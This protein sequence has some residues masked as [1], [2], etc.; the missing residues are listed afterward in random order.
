VIGFTNG[1][2]VLIASTFGLQIDKV[3]GEFWLRLETIAA[4]FRT[5]SRRRDEHGPSPL[6][7]LDSPFRRQNR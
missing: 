4:N 3:P 2:A 5:L 7:P 6:H 1:I